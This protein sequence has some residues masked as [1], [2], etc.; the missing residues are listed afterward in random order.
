MMLC[1]KCQKNPATVHIQQFLLNGQKSELRICQE[2][3]FKMSAINLNNPEAF[4]QFENVFKGFLEQMNSQFFTANPGAPSPEPILVSCKQCGMTYDEFKKTG[5][6]GCETCYTSF[7]K[8]VK[9]LLKSVQ[10]STRHEGKYPRRLGSDIMQKRQTN[11]LRVE[12]KKAINEENYEE[13]ARLRD[14]I[15]A[16]EASTSDESE[17]VS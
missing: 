1:T 2:C 16:I 6:L 4:M 13:A 7:S 12:L 11:D 9:S 5:K 17:V 15:R 3:A 14:E 8:E 10:G